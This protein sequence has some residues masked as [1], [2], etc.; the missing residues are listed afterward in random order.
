MPALQLEASRRQERRGCWERKDQI[1]DV[2]ETTN[3]KRETIP[4]QTSDMGRKTVSVLA[5]PFLLP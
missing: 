3:V 1:E 2:I 4:S 5:S